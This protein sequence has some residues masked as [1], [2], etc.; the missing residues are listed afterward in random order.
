MTDHF[1]KDIQGQQ[2]ILSFLKRLTFHQR[3]PRSLGPSQVQITNMLG[4]SNSSKV[5][6]KIQMYCFIRQN[7]VSMPSCSLS[8]CSHTQWVSFSPDYISLVWLVFPIIQITFC[9]I[10][11]YWFFFSTFGGLLGCM[12]RGG[13]GGVVGWEHIDWFFSV[14]VRSG[15]GEERRVL[16]QSS[17]CACSDV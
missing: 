10:V 5:P 15:W 3:V 12:K 9:F 4:I 16:T 2:K 13:D 8:A 11:D 17:G 7:W 1:G 14:G 6:A